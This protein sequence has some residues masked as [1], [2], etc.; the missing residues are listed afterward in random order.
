MLEGNHDT[1]TRTPDVRQG[2]ET[3]LMRDVQVLLE[4]VT[5]DAAGRPVRFRYK[6][7]LHVV[8]SHL[9]DWRAGGRCW[10]DEP[11]RDC[12]LVHTGS[13]TAELHREDAD[14]GRWWLARIQ[15]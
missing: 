10:L 3:H 13:I 9:D 8:Q 4:A 2:T 14:H 6:N 15:D 1:R 5:L 12:W 7:R 11:C